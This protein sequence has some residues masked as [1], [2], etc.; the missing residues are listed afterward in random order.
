MTS[1]AFT[2]RI[3]VAAIPAWGPHS[4]DSAYCETFWL[5]TI[6]P[7][8]WC[9]AR[10]LARLA[11]DVEPTVDLAEIAGRI[12]VAGCRHKTERALNRL[13]RFGWADIGL[14]GV[15]LIHAHVTGLAGHQVA[16]LPAPL[17]ALHAQLDC[18]K[19]TA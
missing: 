3:H 9:L 8:C 10:L 11:G 4:I 15:Y 19:V 16:R 7:T 12:G 6:G 13:L 1:V 14:D 18:Q 5:P 2:D 17:R